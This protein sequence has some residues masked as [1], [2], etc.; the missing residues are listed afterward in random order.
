MLRVGCRGNSTDC[1]VDG[2][3]C[4][5]LADAALTFR[6]PAGCLDTTLLEPYTVGDQELNYQ[7]L[8]VGGAPFRRADSDNEQEEKDSYYRGDSFL[9]ASALH[10][11]VIDNAVGGCGVIR[12]LGEKSGYG[13]ITRNGIT[14]ISF[15]SNFP[16]AYTFEQKTSICRDPRWLLFGISVLFSTAVSLFTTSPAAFYVSVYLIVYLQVALASDPPDAVDYLEVVSIGMGRFLPAAFVGWAIYHFCAHDTLTDLTAQFEKTILWLGPC[17]VGALNTDTFDRIPISRLTPHDIQQQPGAIPALIIIVSIITV[18]A[19]AQAWCIWAAGKLPRFLALYAVMAAVLIVMAAL[20]QL[21]LRIHHYI[22]ALLFLPGTALQTRPSL[23]YQGLLVGL[24]INGIARWGFDSILQTPAALLGDAQ[25]GSAL[26]N[27]TVTSIAN[28]TISFAVGGLHDAAAGVAVLV[29]D[30]MRLQVFRPS[31]DVGGLLSVNWTRLHDGEK[32]YFRFGF[33]RTS[34]LGGLW[35]EDFT[36]PGIWDADGQ[37]TH[38]EPG[39]S[40]F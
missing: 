36:K 6:C 12:R 2:R 17:W 19:A 40:R 27:V 30:V 32:E 9:C 4:Q 21:H 10:A 37:W 26:P 5:P 23:V 33:M 8:V 34:P 31:D 38:M 11:G 7:P 25:L 39:P 13:N 35:Y 1:G 29:N 22:L 24:F 20:P 14:S 16:L 3:E 15:D 28:S 18:C